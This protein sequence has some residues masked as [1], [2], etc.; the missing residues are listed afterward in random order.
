MPGQIIQ[1]AP[2]LIKQEI[3][4]VTTPGT[5]YPQ[6]DA[7]V[8]KHLDFLP[9]SLRLFLTNVLA[10]KSRIKLASIGQTIMQATH[11][12]AL[13]APL[14]IGLAIQLH[15]NFASR[16]L[17]D[18]LN[19]LGFCSSYDEVQNFSKNA[20]ADQG[21]DIPSF[22]GEFVHYVGD[23]VDHN[24]R[25]LDGNDTFHG[26]GM[27]A[28]VTPGTTHAKLVPRNV[29]DRRKISTAGHIEIVHPCEP[30]RPF[31]IRYDKRIIKEVSDPCMNI[32]LLWKMSMLFN[33]DQRTNWSGLMQS[34]V[35]REDHPG[36]SSIF[37]L[38]MLDMDPTS[39]TCIYSTLKFMAEHAQ[40]HSVIYPNVTFDQ[41]LRWKAY[42]L[43]LTEPVASAISNVIVRLGAFHTE[44][45]FLALVQLGISC[46][47]QD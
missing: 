17:V 10:G 40:R 6:V 31:A 21:T 19:S 12:R 23:N 5:S 47:N 26:M 11:P 9:Q 2:R 1:T 33:C 16:F 30:R 36:K 41:P 43:T 8:E 45:S 3:K 20:S 13:M 18:S 28:A 7:D 39:N 27:I 32:G 35:T 14:Q 38:P 34:T 24:I 44:M 25:T 15:H 46:Q 29:V 22:G 4:S 42:N 37:F